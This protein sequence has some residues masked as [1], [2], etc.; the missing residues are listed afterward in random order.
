MTNISIFK[1]VI[2]VFLIIL[3]SI[4]S[5]YISALD[6]QNHDYDTSEDP[7][8][9][10]YP[11]LK[12]LTYR[13]AHLTKLEDWDAVYHT[14]K[15]IAS[16][17]KDG[18]VP[19]LYARYYTNQACLNI[20]YRQ[21]PGLMQTK[22]IHTLSLEDQRTLNQV[23][24]DSKEILKSL[25]KIDIHEDNRNFIEGLEHGT[26]VLLATTLEIFKDYHQALE[27][28]TSLV[29]KNADS[30]DIYGIFLHISGLYVQ[31]DDLQAGT[32]FFEKYA[33]SEETEMTRFSALYGCANMM[34]MTNRFDE[35]TVYI[36]RAMLGIEDQELLR[37]GNQL[38]EVIQFKRERYMNTGT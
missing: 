31:I 9:L 30:P 18:T 10:A 33:Q 36:E 38:L 28:L 1:Y 16:K 6:S 5:F 32:D 14:A 8:A 19:N 21:N 3:I 25:H 26:K 15:K 37:R 7:I 11:S 35:A 27:H 13:L 22:K 23:L 4:C 24:K 17:E 20:L 34:L 29:N 12:P 2:L